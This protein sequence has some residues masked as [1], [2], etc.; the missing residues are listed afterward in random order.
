VAVAGETATLSVTVTG[1]FA[2]FE[3]SAVLVADTVTDAGLGTIA[4][5]M[6]K[7]EDDTV[8]RVIF[9]PETPFTAQFTS[10]L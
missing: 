9:P 4:G 1:E 6:N 2:D 8:P 7:P 3:A 10:L 5:A